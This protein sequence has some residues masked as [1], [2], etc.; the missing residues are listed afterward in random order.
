MPFGEEGEICISGPA[1]M[2][3]YLDNPEETEKALRVHAD[4]LTW[5]HTGDICSRDDDGYFYFKFTIK[6]DAESQRI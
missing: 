5:L 3:G 6:A 2:L 1:V 4:G